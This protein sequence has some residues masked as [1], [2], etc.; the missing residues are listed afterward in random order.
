MHRI[1]IIPIFARKFQHIPFEIKPL[2]V[3]NRIH[4]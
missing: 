2:L 4:F 3:R 1:E